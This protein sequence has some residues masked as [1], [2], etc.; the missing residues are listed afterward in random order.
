M[1]GVVMQ[2]DLNHQDDAKAI[3]H[4]LS[5]VFRKVVRLVIG[6]VSLPALTEILKAIYVE[7]AE[8]KLIRE[9]SK[10]TKS[11]IALMTG[12]DTR[13]VSSLTAQSLDTTIQSQS[14]NPEN[15]LIDMWN[16]DPFFHDPKTGKPAR[17]PIVGRGRTFQTLVLRAIG[18]NITVK[19][20]ISRLQASG[21]IK[22]IRAD[23]EEV[24]L[25]SIFYSPVSTDRAK[26][27]EVGLIEASRVLS[28]VI[29]NMSSDPKVR[30]PQQGRWTYRLDPENYKEFRKR[31]RELL[32]RQIK[33]GESLL[34]EFE[35]AAKEPGQITVGI[36][37]YQ[38]S[39]H[40]PEEEEE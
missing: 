35:E 19:T 23:V 26:Q 1:P 20:V 27:T 21:N 3:T 25:I 6:S 15:T 9:G 31:V 8:R 17:L 5:R 10:P 22:V 16:S 13:V 32:G 36:G 14:I 30:V 40:E 12:L 38:W 7:E 37:W 11:A 29:H 24:E 28:A 4:I 2:N 33:E 18:R 39:D 34:E